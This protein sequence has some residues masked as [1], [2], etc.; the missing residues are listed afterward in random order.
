MDLTRALIEWLIANGPL[1]LGLV[2]FICALGVP[3]PIPVLMIAAGALVRQ[4]HITLHTAILVTA[5]SAL[6]AE[7]IYYTAGRKLGPLARARL[8][9]GPRGQRY[10]A[11]YDEAARRFGQRPG[12]TVYLTRWLI[13]P[14]GIP[15]NLIAGAARLSLRRFVICAL[16]GNLMW[17][18][19]YTAVGYALG[20]EW[21]NVS[22]VLDRYKVWF[23]AAAL[24]IGLAL[25]AHRYRAALATALRR[26]ARA[27]FPALPLRRPAIEPVEVIDPADKPR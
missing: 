10:A 3:L 24:A 23:A 20:A 16:L 13:A 6:L 18:A 1:T 7:L 17:I 12:L 11:I 21:Q 5:G 2:A 22:P 27:A 15:T 14:L 26:A 19:A 8:S 4:G 9:R 25:L